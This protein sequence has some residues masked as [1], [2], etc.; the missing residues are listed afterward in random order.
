MAE[1]EDGQEKSEEPSGKRIEQAREK[2]QVAQSK[3]LGTFLLLIVAGLFFLFA[4]PAMMRSFLQ[5][6]G[7]GFV[8]PRQHVFDTEQLTIYLTTAIFES[9][10][11]FT[12]LFLFLIVAA[13]ISGIVMSGW[14]FSMQA[15]QPKLEKLDPIKGITRL[16]SWQGLVE[17]G[18]S[19]AKF[20]LISSA[21]FLILKV[22][23][24]EF[25]GLGHEPLL[26]GLEHTA[27]LLL[28]SFL[29]LSAVLVLIAII[30][31]PFQLWNHK[32]QLKM[33]LQEVKD[34]HKQTEGS[35]EVKAQIRR[36][37]MEM[38]QRRMMAAVPEAD[39][40]ITNPTHYAVALKYDGG[41]MNAPIVVA[42][43]SDLIAATIRR[44]ADES[45]VAIV[46]A[47]PLARAL[48]HSTEID[49]PI[50]EGLYKAVAQV[51]AYIFHLKEGGEREPEEK[52]LDDLP[53]P[54]KLRRDE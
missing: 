52:V 16:F 40:V 36:A 12:P 27:W 24:G 43:G 35:P 18:K 33:T 26:Q 6:I 30:D 17:L 10:L 25:L 2:G 14:N 38:T 53:I 46:S 19:L 54:T 28:W 49:Q 31:V 23:V 44:L 47:P 37:Q 8:I 29:L 15:L 9:L 20:I 22:Q 48:Y 13:I 39:V 3:E 4:G 21:A 45:G 5:L 51:L 7:E 50:P 42:K 1:N 41:S 11:I 34:E 32:R